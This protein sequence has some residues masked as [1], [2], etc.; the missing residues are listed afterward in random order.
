MESKGAKVILNRLNAFQ[1]RVNKEQLN[2]V[3]LENEPKFYDYFIEEAFV[4]RKLLHKKA[5]FRGNIDYNISL[6]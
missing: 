4:G 5:H 6:N 3:P 1:E 2:R